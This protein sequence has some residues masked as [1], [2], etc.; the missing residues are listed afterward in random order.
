[1]YELDARAGFDA[2]ARIVSTMVYRGI[3]ALES[4]AQLSAL[5]RPQLLNG[6]RQSLIGNSM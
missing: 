1:M 2:P 6:M 3:P 5:T 4:H